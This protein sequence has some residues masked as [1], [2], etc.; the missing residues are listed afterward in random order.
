MPPIN[1][2]INDTVNEGQVET[3]QVTNMEQTQTSKQNETNQMA[4]DMTSPVTTPET[5]PVT[6]QATQSV[7]F[8]VP[9][10]DTMPTSGQVS[11]APVNSGL[12]GETAPVAQPANPNSNTFLIAG[13][14]V[15]IIALLAIAFVIL[16]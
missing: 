9:T 6:P 2:S 14:V 11:S 16:M 15:A 3:P 4:P 1:N 13:G 5:E 12:G 10:I 8:Q 7:A